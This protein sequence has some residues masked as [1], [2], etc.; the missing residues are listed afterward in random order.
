MFHSSG[1]SPLE[2][3]HAVPYGRFCGL[4]GGPCRIFIAPFPLTILA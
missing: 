1:P 3:P 2:L 4:P